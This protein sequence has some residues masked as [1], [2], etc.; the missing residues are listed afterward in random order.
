MREKLNGREYI[1]PI[2]R[3]WLVL[4]Y[5]R[6]SQ[7]FKL[8][9]T[10]FPQLWCMTALSSTTIQFNVVQYSKLHFRAVQCTTPQ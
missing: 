7:D 2:G 8:D 3:P 4:K 10:Q 9:G 6:L 1:F 5:A